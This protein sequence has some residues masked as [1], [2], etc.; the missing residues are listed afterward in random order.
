MPRWLVSDRE[1]G[2]TGNSPAPLSASG[3]RHESGMSDVGQHAQEEACL[4]VCTKR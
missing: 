4:Y 1:G 2:R 3:V